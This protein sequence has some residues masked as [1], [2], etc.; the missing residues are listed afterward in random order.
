MKVV[1]I[2]GARPNF[3]KISP[4][5]HAM[6]NSHFIEPILLH[7]GQHYDYNMS[8]SFFRELAIPEPDVYLNVG[9]D[10]H[11]KQV[12]MIMK[13]FDDFCE[14]HHPELV[15]VV[16]D[17]NST[18]ACSLVAV[19][20]HIK[21]AHIEAG[22]RSYDRSMPEEVNRIVTDSVADLLLPPSKD[23]VENLLKEGHTSEQIHLV[24]NIMIDTLLRN[25]P[26]ILGS[27]IL[28][29]LAIN[30]KEFALL[31]LHRPSNVD[32]IK[33]LG[34]IIE[35]LEIIQDRIKIVFPVHPRTKKRIEEF[36][37]LNR[38]NQSENII[39]TEPLGYFDFGKLVYEANF[40]MTDSG[41][42]QEE[43]TVYQIPCITIR[44]NTERPVTIWEGTNELAGSNK[45]KIVDFANQILDGN[46]KKGKIP[47]LWDGK[48]AERIVHVFEKL[49]L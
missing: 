29:T 32:D 16:G 13:K 12:A 34:N 46:W 20:R 44:D 35:A 14:E 42:I 6:Q 24:G 36:G 38:I 33:S 19:K 28:Q 7:T 43:T 4:L 48:T 9:S 30:P 37:L 5:M 27:D 17:V 11:G 45:E 8:E 41:G 26:K 2:V 31:T 39:L 22:I 1:N 25:Q 18:M 49:N 47:E 40:V 10:T 15:V 3:V 21:V 23:A